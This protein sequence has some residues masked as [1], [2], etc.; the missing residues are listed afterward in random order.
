MET[1]EEIPNDSDL[2]YSQA[3]CLYS[4]PHFIA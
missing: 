3:W 1:G 4:R 2:D